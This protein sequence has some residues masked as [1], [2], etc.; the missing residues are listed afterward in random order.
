MD[1]C[2]LRGEHVCAERVNI[3][4]WG[5]NMCVLRG[6]HVCLRSEHVSSER[7]TCVSWG[8]EHMS[9]EV[10]M[11]ILRVVHVCSEGWTCVN[12]YLLWLLCIFFGCFVTSCCVSLWF[13]LFCYYSLYACF[14]PKDGLKG[15]GGSRW[16]GR[17]GETGKRGGRES[18]IRIYCMKQIYFQ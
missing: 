12:L 16:E 15:Q 17:W 1:M 11:C 8:G 2:F 6:K 5:V 9:W 18:V 3:C 14:F 7:W 10:S 13:I 4:A